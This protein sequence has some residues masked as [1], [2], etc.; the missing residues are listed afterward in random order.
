MRSH[1]GD[2]PCEFGLGSI[3]RSFGAITIPI[4]ILNLLRW[5]TKAL[6]G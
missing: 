3:S 2:Q 5:I 1:E 6:S 4:V